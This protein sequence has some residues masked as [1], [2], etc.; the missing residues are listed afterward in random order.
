[1]NWRVD[2]IGEGPLSPK[3]GAVGQK[4]FQGGC[5]MQKLRVMQ[6]GEFL[7]QC[8]LRVARGKL[9]FTLYLPPRLVPPFKPLRPQE[10]VDEVVGLRYRAFAKP[11]I[12]DG[13]WLIRVEAEEISPFNNITIPKEMSEKVKTQ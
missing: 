10:I 7:A 2:G 9:R 11:N 13:G 4:N 12:V 6:L 1:M 3:V 5:A 8:R